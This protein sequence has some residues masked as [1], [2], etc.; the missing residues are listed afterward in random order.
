MIARKVCLF[1]LDNISPAPARIQSWMLL[2]GSGC[3]S[4]RNC[5]AAEVLNGAFRG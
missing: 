2:M 4:N 5:I 1:P 3:G